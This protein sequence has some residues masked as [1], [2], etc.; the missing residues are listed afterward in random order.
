MNHASS[1]RPSGELY[2]CV[3]NSKPMFVGVTSFDGRGMV[4]PV[5]RTFALCDTDKDSGFCVLVPLSAK[6]SI[7][8][9]CL[10]AMMF[11]SRHPANSEM[12]IIN[13][14]YILFLI[15]FHQSLPILSA[16][17]GKRLSMPSVLD[18]PEL[19]WLF[20]FNALF[21][22]TSCAKQE[23]K[24]KNANKYDLIKSFQFLVFSRPNS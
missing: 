22:L 6:C 11:S 5:K 24:D 8:Y 7:A 1:S 20:G 15:E 16:V 18:L 10:Y 3:S 14:T 9:A 12:T 13:S 17:P 23:F 4:I 19:L 2:L 21:I